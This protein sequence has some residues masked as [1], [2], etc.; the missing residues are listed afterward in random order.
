MLQAER[1][2]IKR[3]HPEASSTDILKRLG[4]KWKTADAET[5]AKYE[6]LY[7]E[8]KAKADEEMKAYEAT[9]EQL[10]SDRKLNLGELMRLKNKKIVID[11]EKYGM[12]NDF[13][14]YTIK[15]V[16]HIDFTKV[17]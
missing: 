13:L 15:P 3:D 16:S 14:D 4:E 9:Y 7:K 2:N 6:A 8:N 11:V 5:K 10:E 1:E 17:P 12:L